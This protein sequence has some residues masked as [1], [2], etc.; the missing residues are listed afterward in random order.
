MK[1]KLVRMVGG[2]MHKCSM[3]SSNLPKARYDMGYTIC[4]KCSIE[5]KK[6]G[7]VIYPHKTGAFVQVVSKSTQENL[8]K[9][10]RRGYRTSGA[11]KNYKDIV[12]DTKD[13]DLDKGAKSSGYRSSHINNN[14]IKYNKV[15]QMVKSYYH[16]WGY[17]RAVE[18]LRE[19]N[20][21]GK[22][23]LTDRCKLQD[24]INN[25]YLSS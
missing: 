17:N 18:Y 24:V 10:D 25:M 2:Y 21:G 14:F 4:T 6:V 5:E 20:S 11:F 3:C 23:P 15:L 8:N 12:V 13:K 19:L 22:I 7:H 16:E 9:L 1:V